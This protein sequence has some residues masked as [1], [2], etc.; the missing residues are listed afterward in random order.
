MAYEMLLREGKINGMTLPHRIITGPMER[1]LANRDGSIN[2]RY[3]DYLIERAKGGAALIQVES[4]YVDPI[5]MGHWYQVG[6]HGD[7]V[8][9]G[10]KRLADAV[11]AH[12]A[13]CALEIYLGGRETPSYMSMSQPIA[14]SVVKCEVLEAIP[15]PREMTQKDINHAIGLFAD[16]ARRIVEAGMDM[17]HLHGAHGYLLSQFLSPYSNRRSDQYGGSRENRA[18]FGLEILKEVRKTVGDDFPIGYRLTAEEYIDDGLMIEDAVDF[19]KRLVDNG[20][21]LID[22]SGGIYESFHLIIQGAEAPKGAFVQN[23]ATIKK[24]VG[25]SVPVSVA[26]K[27]SDPEFANEVMEREGIDFIS[28]TRAFHADPHYVRKIKEDRAEDV[29][30]CIACHHCTSLLE[31]NEVTSCAVNPHSTNERSRKIHP[32]KKGRKVMVVG[33]G[34]AG[35]HAARILARQGQQVSLFEQSSEL[36]GQMRYSSRVADDYGYLV[37]YLTHMMDKLNVDV[38]LNTTVDRKTVEAFAPDAA[39]IATGARGGINFW[40]MVGNP[41]VFDLFSALDRP[42]DDWEDKVVITTG[43]SHEC[44]AALYIAGRGAEVYVA[45]AKHEFSEDKMSP[46]KE[47]LLMSLQNLPT[48]HLLAETTVEEIGEGYVVFQ[49]HG[50]HRREE[51]VGSVVIGGRVSNNELYDE[52]Q[53]A[54]P[55]LEVYNVGDSVMPREVFDASHDAAEAAQLIGLR[56]S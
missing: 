16:A 33:G 53:A 46:G 30:P 9:E 42:D 39:V 41:N 40:T 14:P 28:L 11:H 51:G 38:H 2:Q 56:T 47:L 25:D 29:L 43:E 32:V 8:I 34:P 18:R 20:I 44:F 17:V 13:K 26:Q 31:L 12:G 35:M 23:A 15:T 50:E 49:K 54:D 10:L 24:A 3:I 4:T 27:L 21:D 36:G 55:D 48:V 19:S 45:E 6:C 5:G 7:H 52:L 1:G 37:T 22:V